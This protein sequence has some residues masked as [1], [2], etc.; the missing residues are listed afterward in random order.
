MKETVA[1]CCS[2]LQC[3]AVCCSNENAAGGDAHKSDA[4]VPVDVT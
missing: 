4:R 2:V 1:V 3:V